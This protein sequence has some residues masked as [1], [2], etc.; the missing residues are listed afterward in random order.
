MVVTLLPRLSA[1][2]RLVAFLPQSMQTVALTIP[3]GRS[4]K[5]LFYSPSWT[6]CMTK[7]QILA[8]GLISALMRSLES[9]Y[10]TQT[11]AA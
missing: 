3:A 1:E 5:D 6:G 10:P 8:A 9:L 11:A 7:R 2:Q 4:G